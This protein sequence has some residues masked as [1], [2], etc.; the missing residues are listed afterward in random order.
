MCS[1]QKLKFII[2]GVEIAKFE[3]RNS[4]KSGELELKFCSIS[5]FIAQKLGKFLC[6]L[7]Y[8]LQISRV[9]LINN[10]APDKTSKNLNRAQTVV[11]LTSERGKS[12]F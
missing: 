2:C 11:G 7:Q 8:F 10:E 3:K 1:R 9:G 4:P 6:A 5:E 12:Y